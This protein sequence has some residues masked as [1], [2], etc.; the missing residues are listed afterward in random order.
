[1]PYCNTL[2]KFRHAGCCWILCSFFLVRYLSVPLVVLTCIFTYY[3]LVRSSLFLCKCLQCLSV[4]FK[5]I[6]LKMWYFT[7]LFLT[8]FPSI[9]SSYFDFLHF[10][11]YC[12]NVPHVSY[13]PYCVM[14]VCLLQG[15]LL[16]I[17]KKRWIQISPERC[18]WNLIL[19]Y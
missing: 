18:L 17:L 3:S 14:S 4:V 19:H 8:N 2:K 9:Y 5:N 16:D 7:F 1:M 13:W 11:L 12:L 10:F 6:V 15:P